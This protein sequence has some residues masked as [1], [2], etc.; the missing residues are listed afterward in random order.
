MTDADQSAELK[1]RVDTA[2]KNAQ[3]LEIVGTG[4]KRFYGNSVDAETLDVSQ[5]CG[6]VAY[7][8][9]ELVITARAGTPIAEVNATLAKHNQMLAFEPPLLGGAGTIGGALATGLSG[10]RRPFWGSARDMVLGIRLLNGHGELMRFGGEVM[11][12]VAGYDTARLNVAALGTLGVILEASLKV[13]PAPPT[14]AT[15]ALEIPAQDCHARTEQWLREGRPLSAVSHDG[16]RLF[17]RLS[18]TQSAVNDALNQLGGEQMDADQADGFWQSV[19]DHTHAFFT[20]DAPI[21]RISLPPG[22]DPNHFPSPRFIDWAGQQIWLRGDHDADELRTHAASFGGSATCF[23]QRP[24]S[25]AAFQPLDAVQTRLHQGL[26]KAF[27]PQAIFN[28]GRLY[29][30]LEDA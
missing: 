14:H 3:P 25:I 5:H 21:W 17:V 16:E 4:S 24:D 15:L 29:P 11:K 28:P 12:N 22:V 30:D 23:N 8:P 7:E 1:S 20:T 6:I 2:L 18:G 27:D 19:R 9:T 10:P 26:K 13:L